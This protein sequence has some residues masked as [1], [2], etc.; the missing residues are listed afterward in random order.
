MFIDCV[1][2]IF[3]FLCIGV[4]YKIVMS[5][6]GKIYEPDTE[7]NSVTSEEA[8]VLE[9]VVNMNVWFSNYQESPTVQ[10]NQITIAPIASMESID[11]S[12][13]IDPPPAYEETPKY[14]DCVLNI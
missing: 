10:T 9:R 14:D 12:V 1:F 11:T 6:C 13:N 8:Q 5:I 2:D 4:I 3:V 7:I